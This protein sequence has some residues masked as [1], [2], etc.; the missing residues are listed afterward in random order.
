MPSSTSPWDQG[1]TT[2]QYLNTTLEEGGAF[3][4]PAHTGA[5]S[6]AH[7]DTNE[8][9]NVGVD[10]ASASASAHASGSN[11]PPRP[12]H[13]S[14]QGAGSGSGSGY[15]SASGHGGQAGFT[16]AQR[17]A[18]ARG[19]P[20]SNSNVSSSSSSSAQKEAESFAQREKRLEA[21]TI[22]DSTE[23]LIW[24]AAARN[25]SVVQTR[26]YYTDIVLGMFGRE[27]MWQEEWEVSP[28]VRGE[29]G[30][31]SPVGKGKGKGKERERGGTPRRR[32]AFV[33]GGE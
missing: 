27:K 20:F 28:R 23:M 22:L 30:R 14:G 9:S 19:K 4:G 26:R 6:S 24:Y 21:A 2:G 18:Q 11:T 1:N 8:S 33:E 5:A 12:R 10:T 17:S 32:S 7:T 15:G 31:A 16:A 3:A 13:T 25:E 29:A